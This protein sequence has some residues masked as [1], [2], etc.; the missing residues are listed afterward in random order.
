MTIWCKHVYRLELQK[1]LNFCAA[2][3]SVRLDIETKFLISNYW[4]P[5]QKLKYGH[6]V[7]ISSLTGECAAQKFKNFCSSNLWTCLHHMVILR[8]QNKITNF[9]MIL[10]WARPFNAAA[11]QFVR[12]R[13][14]FYFQWPHFLY[15]FGGVFGHSGVLSSFLILPIPLCSFSCHDTGHRMPEIWRGT[16]PSSPTSP[17]RGP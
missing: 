8:S 2:H 7:S 14:V 6:L 4:Q 15:W 10:A 3:S 5:C 13:R 16:R 9:F 17:G 12:L 11:W 1:F